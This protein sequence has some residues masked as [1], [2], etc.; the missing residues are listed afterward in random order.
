[1]AAL[2]AMPTVHNPLGCTMPVGA[3]ERLAALV[4]RHRVP[5]IEDIVYA[6]LQFSDPPEPAVKSFDRDGW[7]IVC[8]GFSKTLAPDYRI[9]WMH[10]GRYTRTV[11]QLKFAS[12]CAEPKLLCE[13]V[14]RFLESGSYE[15]HVKSLRRL[16]ESQVTTVRG[17][18]SSHFPIGTRATQPVG[19][20]LL[21]VELPPSIDSLKL[22]H[23]ALNERIT[24]LPGQV[25]SKGERYRYCVRLSCCQE[26]DDRFVDAI[27]T[28]GGL[29]HGVL[30]KR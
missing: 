25:Y 13:A 10:A 8:S 21:W 15:H 23:A 4:H 6:E 17:L 29:A 14:G 11:Q 16:Y 2:V 22:F 20:F 24:I 30:Q 19:G 26:V 5:L 27:R 7:V 9:G 28:L 3:K 1:M 12:S 18:I